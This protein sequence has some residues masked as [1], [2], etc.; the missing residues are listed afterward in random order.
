M[1]RLSIVRHVLKINIILIAITL[2]GVNTCFAKHVHHHHK[3]YYAARAHN[4]MLA[5]LEPQKE[6]KR[7][8]ALVNQTIGT[9]NY[10]KYKF[11]GSRFDS[12]KGVYIIDCSN[13]VDHLLAKVNRPAYRSLVNSSGSDTPNTQHYYEFFKSLPAGNSHYWNKVEAVA[14]LQAG[15]ILVFRKE[16]SYDSSGHIMVVMKKPLKNTDTFEVQVADSAPVGHSHDTRLPH[17]SGIGIGTLLLKVNLKTGKPFAY[18]WREGSYWKRN[19]HFA[20]A[21]PLDIRS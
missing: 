13:F 18:A 9:L 11:G 20:M 8:V 15:D 14:E 5:Q 12:S 17:V 10:S 3:I 6:N 19:I 1:L 7:I 4:K 16:S 21:R 2:F